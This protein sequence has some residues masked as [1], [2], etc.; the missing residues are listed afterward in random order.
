MGDPSLSFLSVVSMLVTPF[1][2][3]VGWPDGEVSGGIA[4]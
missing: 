4:W 3:P 2:A 1:I